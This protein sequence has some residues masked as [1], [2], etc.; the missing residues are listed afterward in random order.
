MRSEWVT[1]L[2]LINNHAM[3]MYGLWRRTSTLS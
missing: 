1:L 3:L 2:Y